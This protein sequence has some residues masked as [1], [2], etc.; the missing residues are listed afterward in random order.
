MTATADLVTIWDRAQGL[1]PLNRAQFLSRLALSAAEE[2]VDDIPIGQT[3]SRIFRLRSV[4]FGSDML[5][6]ASCSSCGTTLEIAVRVEDF[7]AAAPAPGDA[8]TLHEIAANNET[9]RFRLP[10][11]DDLAAIEPGTAPEDAAARL[12]G[13]CIVDP[14][15]GFPEIVGQ[16][17]LARMAELDPLADTMLHLT[18]ES[19][20]S[21]FDCAFDIAAF[22]WREIEASAARIL[23]DVHTI[24]RIYGW[25]EGDIL[26]LTPA[27][28]QVY[29][30][31]IGN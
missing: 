3:N 27:R 22:T 29:L 28:R 4:L 18:C 9:V 24:A 19:C 26:G 16:L 5:A 11:L 15:T 31:L 1:G 23:G 17:V 21:H 20:G 13:A 10:T 2:A 14:Q 25:T 12:L 6:V 8:S 30:D 7:L